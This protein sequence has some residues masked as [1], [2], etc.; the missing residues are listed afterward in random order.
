MH[1]CSAHVVDGIR[2][3][4]WRWQER[5]VKLTIAR[6]PRKILKYIRRQLRLF[7]FWL[8]FFSLKLS[9]HRLF[10]DYFLS[11]ASYQK[12]NLV[13]FNVSINIKYVLKIVKIFKFNKY[14]VKHHDTGFK[15]YI[16]CV[17]QEYY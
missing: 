7:F 4:W 6:E 9:L 3:M 13:R 17:W 8:Y 12:S 11:T 2:L 1:S 16:V 10:Y 14:K 5:G 15:M